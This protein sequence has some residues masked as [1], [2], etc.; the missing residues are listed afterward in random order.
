MQAERKK[1]KAGININ[2]RSIGGFLMEKYYNA[3]RQVLVIE[4]LMK[5]SKDLCKKKRKV[6]GKSGLDI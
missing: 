2:L 6:G 3:F 5:H 1:A 4:Y